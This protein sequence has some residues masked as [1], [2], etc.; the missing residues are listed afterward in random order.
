MNRRSANLITAILFCRCPRCRKGKMFPYNIFNILKMTKMHKSCPVC[1]QDLIPEPG[2]Y[3]GAMYFSYAFQVAILISTVVA[4]SVLVDKP[5]FLHYAV[6]ALSISVLL[7]PVTFRLS[8][9]LML[10]LFGGIK[11]DRNS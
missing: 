8:R 4:V 11:Y 10:H 2:F 7:L 6:P 1:R 5:G 9:S 3:Y